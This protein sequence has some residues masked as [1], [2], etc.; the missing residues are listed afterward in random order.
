MREKGGVN[1]N[2]SK[3]RTCVEDRRGGGENNLDSAPEAKRGKSEKG[4]AFI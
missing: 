3:S 4:G 2:Y 1:F